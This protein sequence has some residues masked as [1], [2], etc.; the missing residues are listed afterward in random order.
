MHFKV[1]FGAGAGAGPPGPVLGAGPVI[2]GGTPGPGGP[3]APGAPAG[4]PAPGASPPTASGGGAEPDW[5]CGGCC[6]A[7]EGAPN[8]PR[9]TGVVLPLP[10]PPLPLGVD[11]PPGTPDGLDCCASVDV[12]VVLETWRDPD[13]RR[14]LVEPELFGECCEPREAVRGGGGPGGLGPFRGLP[15]GSV[16]VMDIRFAIGL[17][18]G[19]TDGVGGVESP[20]DTGGIG[21]G[22]GYNLYRCTTGAFT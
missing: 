13:D 19:T 20:I 1:G 2:P 9:A 11:A 12:T 21:I 3:A 16:S 22:A 8:G 15:G 18:S 17:C 5:D 14:P 6:W 7:M 10:L 4:P